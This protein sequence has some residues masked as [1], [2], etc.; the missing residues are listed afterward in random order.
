[1]ALQSLLLTLSMLSHSRDTTVVQPVV[2][3]TL[4]VQDTI[5][6][7]T[8]RL[9]YVV[10]DGVNF[11][12]SVALTYARPLHWQKRNFLF[13]GGAL[14]GSAS[15]LLIEQPVYNLLQRNQTEGLDRI[16]RV[17][18]WLGKPTVNYPFMLAVWGSGVIV[19]NDWLRDTGIMVI[20]S[21]TASGLIQTAAKDLVGRSRPGSGLG[22]F[23]FR[24]L[25]G[26]AY[27]SFPSGHATLSVATAWILAKRV[28]FIPLKIVFYALPVITGVSRIYVGAH[29]VSDVL[30]GSALGI[31]CAES[32][33]R[34]Y[35]I[36]RA[37]SAFRAIRVIPGV[38]S[39][40]LVMQ[41]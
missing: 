29:W 5:R 35:P 22:P 28:N 39:A 17:G 38:N 16:E 23:S 7:S 40:S 21:V 36:L 26:A 18:F 30:L 19:D 12:K 31:A 24:P 33:L 10:K 2:R 6:P 15:A 20:A 37:K 25:G 27:H 14:L 8:N 3:D 13:L 34:I 11:A 32:V 1:M 41:L 9:S 4:I